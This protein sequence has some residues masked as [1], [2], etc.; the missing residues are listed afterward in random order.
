MQYIDIITALFNTAHVR[1]EKF[2]NQ[3]QTK[4][5]ALREHLSQLIGTLE[6]HAKLPTMRELCATLGV[7][8]M[9]ANRALSE[10]EAGGVIYRRQGSGTFVAP[11][12][13]VTAPGVA[14]VYSR[15]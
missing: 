1:F 4:T 2:T 13:N 15:A 11:R 5:Q 7:S 14:L 6:P 9:T 8:P 10:L 12:A 3:H